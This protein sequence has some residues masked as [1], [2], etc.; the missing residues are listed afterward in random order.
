MIRSPASITTTKTAAVI[1][2]VLSVPLFKAIDNGL[3]DELVGAVEIFVIIHLF[4]A[5][6][7]AGFQCAKCGKIER[8]KFPPEVRSKMMMT[9]AL[10]VVGAI[11]LIV[12]VVGV[13]VALN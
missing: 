1:D 10:M 3:C 12:A 11:A 6:G 2:L 13:L 8:S 5:G 9:S 4:I 7:R